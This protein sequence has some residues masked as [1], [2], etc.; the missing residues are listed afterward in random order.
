MS[1]FLLA[2]Y[3]NQMEPMPFP[4]S[5]KMGQQ[6]LNMHCLTE[7]TAALGTNKLESL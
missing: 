5:W 2:L 3:E 1:L 6:Y 4:F 7:G